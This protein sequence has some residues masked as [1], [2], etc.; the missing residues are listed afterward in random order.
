MCLAIQPFLCCV[1]FIVGLNSPLF[2]I[3]CRNAKF[4]KRISKNKAI[5]FKG[6][7]NRNVKSKPRY[8]ISLLLSFSFL[9][10]GDVT[11]QEY[12]I[13]LVL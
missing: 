6:R 11:W 2:Q 12:R 9:F 8:Y 4:S 1:C 10:T 13:L 3:R 5:P 7:M